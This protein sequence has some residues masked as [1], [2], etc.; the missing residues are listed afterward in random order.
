M[1]IRTIIKLMSN[2]NLKILKILLINKFEFSQKYKKNK[3]H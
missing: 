3:K 2:I 1:I